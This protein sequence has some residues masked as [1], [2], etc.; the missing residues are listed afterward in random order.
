MQTADVGVVQKGSS[1]PGLA[2]CKGQTLR[3]AVGVGKV[4]LQ[5]RICCCRATLPMHEQPHCEQ[6][7]YAQDLA[8]EF[9]G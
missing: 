2:I 3:G 5:Q 1:G 9:P 6:S 7:E 8:F 4:A